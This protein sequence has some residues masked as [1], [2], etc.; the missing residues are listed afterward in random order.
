MPGFTAAASHLETDGHYN[1][2]SMSSAPQSTVQPQ[3]DSKDQ[4]PDP[5]DP[6]PDPPPPDLGLDAAN[7]FAS[8]REQWLGEI[9]SNMG[10]L[11][12]GSTQQAIVQNC[13]DSCKRDYLA[14]ILT[15]LDAPVLKRC[16]DQKKR[17]YQACMSFCVP[18]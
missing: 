5:T 14:A 16:F 8:F 18:D 10:V 1:T 2:V 15:C 6:D 12:G 7:P 9:G 13:Q 3:L 17:Q 11:Y 4:Y